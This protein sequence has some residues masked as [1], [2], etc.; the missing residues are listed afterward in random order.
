M[1]RLFKKEHCS[2]TEWMVSC[3]QSRSRC[4]NPQRA[5]DRQYGRRGLIWIQTLR[6]TLGRALTPRIMFDAGYGDG[7]V[8]PRGRAAPR[9]IVSITFIH[10]CP[11][12]NEATP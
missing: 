4:G 12:G 11:N 2:I 9:T 7:E 6:N 8:L 1:G 5:T 3:T 10:V